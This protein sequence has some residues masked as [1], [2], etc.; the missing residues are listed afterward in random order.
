MGEYKCAAAG[1]LRGCSGTWK[2]VLNA[3]AEGWLLHPS[4]THNCLLNKD[5]LDLSQES[6]CGP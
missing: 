1:K 3:H 2:I 5:E 4:P 6:R